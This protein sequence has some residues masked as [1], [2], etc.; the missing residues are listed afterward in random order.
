MRVSRS[1]DI[2]APID[3]AWRIAAHDFDQISRWASL[4]SSS[5]AAQGSAPGPGGPEMTGRVC[6]TRFGASSETF[7]AY[8]EQAR[9]FTYAAEAEGQPGFIQEAFNTWALEPTGRQSCRLT[10]TIDMRLN[11]GFNT[12][13]KLPMTVQMRRLLDLN[14]EELRYFIETGL[15]HPRKVAAMEKS[16]AKSI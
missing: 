7:T 10:M 6:Q 5:S 3:Q 2:D 14:L 12:I 11:R 16:K 15:P 13:M 1:I 9:T 4:V 8:D